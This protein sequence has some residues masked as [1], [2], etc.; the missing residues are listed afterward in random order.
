MAGAET[1]SDGTLWNEGGVDVTEGEV[2]ARSACGHT[3]GGLL[4]ASGL[5]DGENGVEGG[6]RASPVGKSGHLCLERGW[7]GGGGGM[8]LVEAGEGVGWTGGHDE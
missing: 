1:G 8:A 3:L 7:N 5:E 2:G 4:W 6:W